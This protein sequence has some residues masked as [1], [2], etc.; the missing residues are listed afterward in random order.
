MPKFTPLIDATGEVC[1]LTVA[2]R[3]RFRPV[4]EPLPAILLAKLQGRGSQKAPTKER[5]TICMLADVTQRFRDAGDGW[6][7]REHAVL[8]DCLKSHQPANG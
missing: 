3:R 2:D 8:K 1:E 4:N 6:Q 5:I 7:T